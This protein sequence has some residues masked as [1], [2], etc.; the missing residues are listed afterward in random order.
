MP[1][2]WYSDLFITCEI[3]QNNDS[4][5]RGKLAAF[6]TK[7]GTEIMNV[8]VAGKDLFEFADQITN[9][10]LDAIYTE[11]ISLDNFKG[12][13]DLPTSS[14][15]TNNKEAFQHYIMG[16]SYSEY[17]NDFGNAIKELEKALEL[18][19]NCVQCASDLSNIYLA[20]NNGQKS[21]EYSSSAMQGVEVLSERQ[22]FRIK[23]SYY[24]RSNNMSKAIALFEM[25]KK[26]YPSNIEPYSSLIQFYPVFE[27]PDKAIE[28]G[29]EAVEAG[30]KGSFLIS[31]ANLFSSKGDYENALKYYEQYR[32]SYPKR[33]EE[34]TA[35]GQIHMRAGK[36]DLA[37]EHYQ[38]LELLKPQDYNIKKQIANVAR[39]K[40]E[41]SKAEKLYDEAL[42]LCKNTSD[43][44]SILKSKEILL[45]KIGQSE[46][47]L[48]DIGKPIQSNV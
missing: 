15:I 45:S 8:D 38:S 33:A 35:I 43:T 14:L 34:S 48:W 7:D 25:W 12:Y 37:L 26:V 30:H 6:Y 21:M 40:G 24:L 22:Q 4:G 27:G 11:D 1:Q 3:T 42:K 29:I 32:E 17:S 41:F 10:Y 13:T 16:L 23:S 19:P 47:G 5:I 18:D 20:I 36:F 2:T 28:V 39:R 44:V 9:E 46:S 31:V